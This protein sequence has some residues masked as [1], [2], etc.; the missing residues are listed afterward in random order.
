M[1]NRWK[2]NNYIDEKEHKKTYIT[3]ANLSRAYALPKTHKKTK[4]L[5]YR[6]IVSSVGSPLHNFAKYLLNILKNGLEDHPYTIKNSNEFVEKIREI[7]IPEDHVLMSLDVTSLFTNIP[8]ELVLKG[9]ESRW[10]LI[11]PHTTI[12]WNEMKLALNLILTSTFF[13]FDGQLYHQFEGSPM[14]NPLSPFFSEVV[15][16]DL[17]NKR[18]SLLD[19]IPKFFVRY[20]DDIFCII[21]ADK[22]QYTTR[23]FEKHHDSLKFTHEMEEERKLN[24]LDVLVCNVDGIIKTDWYQ[25]ST[26]SGRVLNFFSNHP[27][28]QKKAMVFNLVDKA[29][30]LSNSEY[31]KK[32]LD[33][34]KEILLKN[35]YSLKFIEKYIKIRISKHKREKNNDKN[36][37]KDCPKENWMVLPYIEQVTKP[38]FKYL[39]KIKVKPIYKVGNKLNSIVKR[40]K[41]KL[42]K[43]NQHN[44]VYKIDC[45]NCDSCYIGETK[46]AVGIRIKE[47]RQNINLTDSD[48]HNVVTLHRINTGHNMKWDEFKILDVE[49]NYYKR[50][51]SEMLHIK[52]TKNTLNVQRDTDRIK[53]IYN[54]T[55]EFIDNKVKKKKKKKV[56]SS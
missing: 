33:L 49:S 54:S 11:Q 25:K 34:V 20:V 5:T 43:I 21:P 52:T 55:L 10:H 18:I 8:N 9:V 53:D 56:S 2:N 13:T 50:D 22:V 47:H 19:Y 26:Y 32:N 3:S 30:L 28:A 39:K 46:R 4:H 24:F 44:V 42:N 48:K 14:G 17:E 7:D 38:F 16:R 41:E 36:V 15:M 35:S 40:G 29:W 27:I 37:K 45:D 12:P 51:V 6:I 31:R 1:L 23:M